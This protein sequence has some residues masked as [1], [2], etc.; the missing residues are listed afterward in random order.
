M[1]AVLHGRSESAVQMAERIEADAV[2]FVD[3]EPTDDMAVLVLKALPV[4]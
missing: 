1:T 4:P 3:S 2:G